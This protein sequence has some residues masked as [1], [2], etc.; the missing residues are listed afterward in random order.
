MPRR[1]CPVPDGELSHAP[2]RQRQRARAQAHLADRPGDRRARARVRGAAGRGVPGADGRVP[3]AARRGRD[4]RRPPAA[5]VCRGARGGAA[6]DRASPLRRADGRRHRAPPGQDRRD[7]DRR[8]QDAGGDPPALPERARG[9]GRAP[10]HGQRLPRPAR[11][12]VDGARLPLPRAQR[13]LDHP[14]RELPLRSHLHPEG[15]PLSAPAA[16]RA[17]RRLPLRHHLRDQQQFGFDYLRD[18]MKFSLDEYVQR[19]LYYAIV[20]EVDNILIDEART[21]L[22]ISGPAEESS[23]KYYTV[24]RI[25]PRLRRDVDYTIDEKHRSATLTE[26]GVAK[27]ERLLGISNLYDPSQ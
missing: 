22:I 9:P 24:N 23:E 17:A 13:G 8:G 16:R 21:P 7:E 4:P 12:A 18:N 15:L 27:C 11:R 20:D 10:R 25:I 1:Q 5:R 14:R 6:D 26:E 3:G 19:E 2:L